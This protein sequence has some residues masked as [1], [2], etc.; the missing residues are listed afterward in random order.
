MRA[1]LLACV[2]CGCAS[3]NAFQHRRPPLAAYAVDFAAFSAGMMVGMDAQFRSGDMQ[4][5]AIGY[6]VAGL[7]WGSWWIAPEVR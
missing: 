5:E 6:C 7:V 2:L 4:Q 1:L 3:G